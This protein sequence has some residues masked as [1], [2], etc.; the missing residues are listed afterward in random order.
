MH[1]SSVLSVCVYCL[2]TTAVYDHHVTACYSLSNLCRLQCYILGY[3]SPLLVV[4]LDSVYTKKYL[5]S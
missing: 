5:Q 4:T 1:L 2:Q 3:T